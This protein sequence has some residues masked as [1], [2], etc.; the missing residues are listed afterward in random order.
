MSESRPAVSVAVIQLCSRPDVSES[1]KSAL[2]LCERAVERGAQWLALPENLAFLGKEGE[3]AKH[4]AAL[5]DSPLLEP[6]RRFAEKH[7]VV[8]FAGSIPERSSD[9]Q[10]AF[11][12]SVVL[13]RDGA[14]LASY[15]KIHLFDVEL[16]DGRVLKE[17]DGLVAGTDDVVVDV[18]GWRVGLSVCYDLRF[19]EL[20]RRA[21]AAGAEVL[22][23]PSAFTLQTGKDHWEVLLRA[24]AIENQ[25]YV[26]AAGQYGNHFGD[27]VSWG[28]S[29]IADPWGAIVARASDRPAIALATLDRDYLEHVRLRFPALKHRTDL[30]PKASS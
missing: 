10:R 16:P 28:H 25:C 12:S 30:Q 26:V 23:V 29:L 4:A 2:V 9:P 17:S 8:V 15:R 3:A 22:M 14:T 1:I 24:R 7:Q 18:D 20:Y 13:G 27:R 6:F 11:N 19:P 21:S 5:D